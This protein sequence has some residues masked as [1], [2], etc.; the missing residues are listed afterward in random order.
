MAQVNPKVDG[1]T[2]LITI[3]ASE[4]KVVGLVTSRSELQKVRRELVGLGVP[5]RMLDL[6]VVDESLLPYPVTDER[7]RRW[8]EDAEESR[9]MDAAVS[10]KGPSLG[11]TRGVS[12]G[13]CCIYLLDSL[14]YP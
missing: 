3:S 12:V 9:A 5:D 13:S 14:H 10:V 7:L 6:Q 4:D 8:L 2:G 1:I 11:M